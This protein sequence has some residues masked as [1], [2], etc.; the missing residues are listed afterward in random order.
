[1]FSEARQARLTADTDTVFHSFIAEAAANSHV[2]TAS[3]LVINIA[4][5]LAV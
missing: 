1:M 2:T 3:V 4:D 5:S